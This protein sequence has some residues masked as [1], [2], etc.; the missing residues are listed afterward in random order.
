MN[1]EKQIERIFI[2]HANKAEKW[3]EVPAAIA[4]WID[5]GVR[6]TIEPKAETRNQLQ[7]RL[8]RR[9]AGIKAESSGDTGEEVIGAWKWDILRPLKLSDEKEHERAA[10][11]EMIVR[12][13]VAMVLANESEFGLSARELIIEASSKV[14]RSRDLGAK[15]FADWLTQIQQIEAENGLQLTSRQDELEKAMY[16]QFESAA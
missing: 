14:V 6:V 13:G 2:T 8:L 3:K 5:G 7:N 15:I 1:E 11:E 4:L 10:R 9:W 16:Q 12:G